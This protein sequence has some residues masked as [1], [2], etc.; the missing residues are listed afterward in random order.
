LPG[1]HQYETQE[2][3]SQALVLPGDMSL[4]MS[5][6][7]EQNLFHWMTE[8]DGKIH[9]YTLTMALKVDA[10]PSSEPLLLFHGRGVGASSETRPAPAGEAGNAAPSRGKEGA[11][12][13]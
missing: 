11:R 1:L 12:A 3:G 7:P 6:G 9:S 2:D 10:L 4:R 8:K 5:L 13:R